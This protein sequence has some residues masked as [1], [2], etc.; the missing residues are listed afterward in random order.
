MNTQ[1][2]FFFENGISTPGLAVLPDKWFER[3]FDFEHLSVS[4]Q[5]LLERLRFTPMRLF[6]Q[7][8]NLTTEQRT[9]QSGGEWS[10]QE[11]I[12]HLL[13]LEPLWYGRIQDILRGEKTLAA[14]DLQNR[15]T[16]EA[17]HNNVPYESLLNEFA[18][19]RK[20]LVR[21]CEENQVVLSTASALHPRLQKPMRI[22]DLMYF[23]A[24]HDDHHIA[25]INYWIDQLGVQP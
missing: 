15:K 10:I 17:G 8:R 25:T 9:L 11:N 5:G 20:K 6:A 23:V 21:C 3:L 1:T 19:A 14:A 12:G 24:E 16:H 7:T 2:I 22:I 4:P 13:D 18:E